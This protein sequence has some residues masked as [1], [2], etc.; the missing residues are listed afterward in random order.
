MNK[1][2]KVDSFNK[3]TSIIAL[4]IVLGTITYA[5]TGPTNSASN[6]NVPAP[7]NVGSILQ[8]KLGGIRILGDSFIGTS[9]SPYSSF[10]IHGKAYSEQ[11]ADGD[12]DATLVTKSYVD[13]KIPSVPINCQ[14]S[15]TTDSNGNF[16]CTRVPV[17]TVYS[18]PGTYYY[19]VPEGVTSIKV[20]GTAGGGSGFQMGANPGGSWFY[21]GSGGGGVID[22]DVAVTPGETLTIVVGGTEQDTYLKRGAVNIISLGAGSRGAFTQPSGG[23]GPLTGQAG[24]YQACVMTS[25]KSSSGANS[26]PAITYTYGYGNYSECDYS[27]GTGGTGYFEING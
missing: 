7:I 10:T 24:V 3:A 13:N 1:S 9:S 19:A 16:L 26:Y 11:T 21:S 14:T 18:N 15:L 12:G 22:Q 5:W 20:T 2:K 6:G 17:K 8:E 25:T 27:P 23:S 4:S